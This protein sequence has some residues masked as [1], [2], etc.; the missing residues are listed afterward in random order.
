MRFSS[1][2]VVPRNAA[3]ICVLLHL[4]FSMD[5]IGGG[6]VH[7]MRV[8]VCVPVC[9]RVDARVRDRHMGTSPVGATRKQQPCA[10]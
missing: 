6:F 1:C 4:C 8:P 5:G 7:Y 9:V 3:R 2:T 10:P